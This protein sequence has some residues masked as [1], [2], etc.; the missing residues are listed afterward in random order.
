MS[1]EIKA[2]CRRCRKEYVFPHPSSKEVSSIDWEKWVLTRTP[3]DVEYAHTL[4]QTQPTFVI[5]T[6]F[7]CHCGGPL[8]V[9]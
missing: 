2:R 7:A 8:Q 3:E 9:V 6:C 1:E 4:Y 5:Q